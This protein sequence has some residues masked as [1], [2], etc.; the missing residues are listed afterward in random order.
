MLFVTND[1]SDTNSDQLC[2]VTYLFEKMA[3]PLSSDWHPDNIV[4]VMHNL[5]PFEYIAPPYSVEV[6]LVNIELKI[7]MLQLA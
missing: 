1:K 3:L 2:P 7:Y 5:I 4:D 6:H